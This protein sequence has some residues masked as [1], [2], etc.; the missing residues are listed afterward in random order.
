MFALLVAGM[1]ALTLVGCAV[2][3]ADLNLPDAPRDFPLAPARTHYHHERTL[4]TAEDLTSGSGDGGFLSALV[5]ARRGGGQGLTRPTSAA[6]Y[7]G[8]VAV[9]NSLDASIS[10]FDFTQRRFS[11]LDL[12]EGGAQRAPQGVAVDRFGNWYVADALSNYVLVLNTQG[13]VQRKLGGSRWLSRL[14]NVAVDSDAQRVYAIDQ[15]AGQHRVRVFDAV[16]G[17]H[18]MD[19]LGGRDASSGAFNLPIDAAVGR[20]GRLYVVDAGNFQVQVFDQQGRFLMRFG[21]AGKRPGQFSR[22]KEI[23]VD[24]QGLVYVVDATFGNVQVFNADG[25]YQYFIGTRGDAGAPATYMLPSGVAV[26]TDGTL[27]VLDQW[28]VKL[29]VYR[30]VRGSDSTKPAPIPNQREPS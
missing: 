4:Y 13:R 10:L 12:T 29:D 2:P 16:S 6:A 5:G 17:A 8:R 24:A 18:L 7:Q 15:A 27:Y 25:V 20:N 28:Y 30:P 14:V 1:L 9:V 11:R 23:A 21:T 26:D 22:P 19:I 3:R